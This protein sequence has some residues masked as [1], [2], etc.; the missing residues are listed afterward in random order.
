MERLSSQFKDSVSDEELKALEYRS[1]N[2]EIFLSIQSRNS[3]RYCP[4][5]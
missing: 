2:G 4:D 5:F 1:F 3:M